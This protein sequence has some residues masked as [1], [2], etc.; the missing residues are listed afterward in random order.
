MN[1]VLAGNF[2]KCERE[3]IQNFKDGGEN[4]EE[5]YLAQCT[6]DGEYK[7]LQC[8]DATSHCWCVDENGKMTGWATR[9]ETKHPSCPDLYGELQQYF[10][11][12]I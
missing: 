6:N 3:R 12:L 4:K 10:I 1:I 8:N 7:R 9:N 11:A 2:T 5:N